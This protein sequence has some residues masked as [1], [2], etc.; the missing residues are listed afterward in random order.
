MSWDERQGRVTRPFDEWKV[1]DRDIRAYLRLASRWS[2]EAYDRIWEEASREP[3]DEDSPDLPHVFHERVDGVWPRDFEWMLL[4]GGLKDA[5]SAFE[6]YLEKAMEE[7]LRCHGFALAHHTDERALKWHQ[8]AAF[9]KQVLGKRLDADQ[10]VKHVRDLRHILTHKRGELR[11]QEDRNRFS[12]DPHGWGAEE[13]SLSLE[14]TF[15]HM[16]VLGRVVRDID[17]LVYRASWGR[18]R[19]PDLGRYLTK[20][21]TE[22]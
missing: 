16:D 21:R 10:P 11:T 7:V 9:Y 4:V 13:V 17:P 12:K 15:A 20:H 19:P 5:V 14:D 22:P 3:A 6:V 8:L 18:V 1:I 2:S